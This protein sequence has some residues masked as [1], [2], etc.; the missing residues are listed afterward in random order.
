MEILIFINTILQIKELDS[1]VEAICLILL[2]LEQLHQEVSNNISQ[3]T[4]LW[5]DG[6]LVYGTW[7]S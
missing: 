2:F 7:F 6:K 1:L 4:R 5:A 3:E